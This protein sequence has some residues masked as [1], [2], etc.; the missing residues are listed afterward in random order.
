MGHEEIRQYILEAAGKAERRIKSAY[1]NPLTGQWHI[2]LDELP[3]QLLFTPPLG[4]TPD[5]MVDKLKEMMR[6]T[7]NPFTVVPEDEIEKLRKGDR[8][9]IF[10]AMQRLQNI[11]DRAIQPLIETL[12][13]K[14]ETTTLRARVAYTLGI[15]GDPIAMEPL[16]ETLS[17]PS[18]EVRLSAI[19]ALEKIGDERALSELKR[20]S[21]TDDSAIPASND[22]TI[23]LRNVAQR[24]IRQIEGRFG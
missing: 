3:N 19:E 5:E 14:H 20:I 22:V 7:F 9:K 10:G 8:D 17:D 23:Y 15:I 18:K 24:A 1:R 12:T 13:N 21:E 6:P 2:D 16:I 11:G 4:V